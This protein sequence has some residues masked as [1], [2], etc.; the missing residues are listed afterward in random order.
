MSIYC[1]AHFTVEYGVA[2]HVDAYYSMVLL[3]MLPGVLFYG[4]AVHVA[5]CTLLST[6][7]C[8]C[9]CCLVY[10]AVY[11]MV[12]L[13]MLMPFNSLELGVGIKRLGCWH[14]EF[15]RHAEFDSLELGVGKQRWG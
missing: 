9:A 1:H 5:W 6:L 15:D 7:W 11:S 14:A 8:C 12:L 4:V 13:C 10:F 3:C 2:V